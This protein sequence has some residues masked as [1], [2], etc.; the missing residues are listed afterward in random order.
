MKFTQDV[1]QRYFIGISNHRSQ[2]HFYCFFQ[3]ESSP[4]EDV[5]FRTCGWEGNR[6]SGGK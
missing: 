2:R 3:T 5:E 4:K 6:M 1:A